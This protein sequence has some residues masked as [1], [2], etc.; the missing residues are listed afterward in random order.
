MQLICRF[1]YPV[2]EPYIQ[3]LAWHPQMSKSTCP[4]P[5]SWSP[6]NLMLFQVSL[7]LMN[8]H[9]SSYTSQKCRCHPCYFFLTSHILSI[10]W[11]CL[12]NISRLTSL[13]NPSTTITWVLLSHL[14]HHNSLPADLATST[15]A[16][17]KMFSTLQLELFFFKGHKAGISLLLKIFHCLPN[18]YL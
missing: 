10:T 15:P 2:S 14:S 12:L 13:P 18:Y 11:L 9:S 17:I 7:Q 3:L 4:N 6:A 16:P 1:K 5:N 8:P